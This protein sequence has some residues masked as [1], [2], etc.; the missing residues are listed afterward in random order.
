MFSLQ[1]EKKS[2]VIKKYDGRMKVCKYVSRLQ[3]IHKAY[4][5]TYKTTGRA[6]KICK[7]ALLV[8]AGALAITLPSLLFVHKL[9]KRDSLHA[10]KN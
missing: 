6:K 4:L 10:S 8:V 2:S 5:F 1:R 7:F 3:C 9:L